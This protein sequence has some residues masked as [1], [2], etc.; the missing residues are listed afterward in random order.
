MKSAAFQ[1]LLNHYRSNKQCLIFEVQIF[2][3]N[4][5]QI[6]N[7]NLVKIAKYSGALDCL[8]WQALG[9]GLTN[10]AKGIRRTLDKAKVHHGVEAL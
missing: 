8:Y 5:N 10:L 7:A 3:D 6:E 1:H 4:G 9:N 2:L